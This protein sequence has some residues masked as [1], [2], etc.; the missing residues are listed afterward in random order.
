[1]KLNQGDT[2]GNIRTLVQEYERI[3]PAEYAN[4]VLGTRA[5]RAQ[6]PETGEMRGS[7]FI[8]RIVCEWPETLDA[9]FKQ[10]LTDEDEAW[11]YTKEGT[12]WFAKSFPEYAV[13]TKV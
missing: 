5:Q 9:I 2:K 13:I 6:G 10:Q 8:E 11:L 1:M 12:R 4:F 7:E 3:F